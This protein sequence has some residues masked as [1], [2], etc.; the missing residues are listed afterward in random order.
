MDPAT[1]V[2]DLPVLLYTHHDYFKTGA[3]AFNSMAGLVNTLQPRAEWSG[4]GAIAK[5]LYLRKRTGDR[6]MEILSFSSDI[7][8]EN[9]Q[10]VPDEF[11]IRKRKIS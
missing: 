7:R 9:D 1:V 8:V 10:P 5:K 4:L 6:K 2:L 3:Q 11:L